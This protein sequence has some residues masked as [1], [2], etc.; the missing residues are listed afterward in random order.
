MPV[1]HVARLATDRAYQGRGIASLLLGQ[2]ADIAIAASGTMGVYALQLV[3]VDQEAY[4]FYLKRGFLPLK[5]GTRYLYIP[6]QTLQSG[7]ST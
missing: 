7:R 1:L 6:L 5:G 4:D 3:A 2:A